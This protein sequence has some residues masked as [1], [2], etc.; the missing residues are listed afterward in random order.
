MSEYQNI[1]YVKDN[2]LKKE[3]LCPDCNVKVNTICDNDCGT[4]HCYCGCEFYLDNDIILIGH[5]PKC[6]Y[7]D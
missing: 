1:E 5:N 3:I 2:D 7:D 4:F 6:G